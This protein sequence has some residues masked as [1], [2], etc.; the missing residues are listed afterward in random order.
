MPRAGMRHLFRTEALRCRV[1]CCSSPSVLLVRCVPEAPLGLRPRR[2][3]RRCCCCLAGTRRR[4][5]LVTFR[6]LLRWLSTLLANRRLRGC[7]F[8]RAALSRQ[9]L[10][11]RTPPPTRR[12]AACGA[13]RV[14]CA[15]STPAFVREAWIS[16]AAQ[17]ALLLEQALCCLCSRRAHRRRPRLCGVRTCAM[18]RD[19]ALRS[20]PP[21]ARRA[22]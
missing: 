14:C 1:G 13:L 8:S 10:T 12:A 22:R 9:R 19:S 11:L 6:L 16:R 17:G 15:S 5:R 18:P 21:P 2:V 20:S 7:S 4:R 3:R